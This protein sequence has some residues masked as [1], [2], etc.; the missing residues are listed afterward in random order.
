MAHVVE[1]LGLVYGGTGGNPE[2]A[3]MM[4]KTINH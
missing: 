3:L 4:P 2:P 1:N